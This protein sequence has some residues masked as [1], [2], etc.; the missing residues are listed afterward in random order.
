MYIN[1]LG[2]TGVNNT[3]SVWAK[4]NNG[5]SNKFRF[6]GNGFITLSN[7]Y[8]ATEEWQR[9]EFTYSCTNVTSGLAGA[10]DSAT[11]DIL[12][13]GF[14]HEVGSYATSY[15]PTSGSAVT[16]VAESCYQGG[17]LDKGVL[18]NTALTLF[19]NSTL[20]SDT[21]N[22]YLEVINLYNLSNG[23]KIRLETRTNNIIHV[24]QSG[25]VNSGDN[26]NSASL[27]SNSINFKKIAIV[28]TQTQFKIF[29]NGNQ[30][31][32]TYNGSYNVNLNSLGFRGD[33]NSVETKIQNKEIKLYN[34]ALT[35]QEL[36]ALTT[37]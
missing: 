15:I 9:F 16:R 20:T 4:S 31:N 3:L 6:F 22:Q 21:T 27:G 28:L 17:L 23:N 1:A 33:N 24:Q 36:I 10:S 25:V 34:T 32:T 11:N 35:D 37:I 8:I 26:F 19:F 12:F 2:T 13:Y 18:N 14:Q 29:A 30:I 7:D 5:S